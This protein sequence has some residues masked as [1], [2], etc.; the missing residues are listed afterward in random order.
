MRNLKLSEKMQRQIL[1]NFDNEGI[2]IYQAFKPEIADE[3]LHLGT[4]G[5]SFSSSFGWMLYRSGYATKPEQER[6]L[7]IKITHEGFQTILA[8]AIPSSFD[9]NIFSSEDEWQK[10]LKHSKVR[11]QW[12]QT[13]IYH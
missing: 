2:I 1:A 8:Q 6:I 9:S 7:K 4:F 3:A 10:I 5:K 12:S 11:Y 13:G